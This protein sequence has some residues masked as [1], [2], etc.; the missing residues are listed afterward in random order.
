M[1]NLRKKKLKLDNE[2]SDPGPSGP[3]GTEGI[4]QS[5]VTKS[6]VFLS[7]ELHAFVHKHCN[8][9]YTGSRVRIWKPFTFAEEGR[10]VYVHWGCSNGLY[11]YWEDT[12]ING[13]V[14]LRPG[15]RFVVDNRG[16]RVGA[17]RVLCRTNTDDLANGKDSLS[18][19]CLKKHYN[20]VL[21]NDIFFWFPTKVRRQSYECCRFRKTCFCELKMRPKL[22]F[23]S[24]SNTRNPG[25]PY[26]G[27]YNRDKSES[28]CDF[29]AWQEEFDHNVDEQCKCGNHTKLIEYPKQTGK[30]FLVCYN[31]HREYPDKG[32][33]LFKQIKYDR[34]SL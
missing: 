17:L 26:Y 5:L 29:F 25:K 18:L 3:S 13:F 11:V 12:N 21:L 27:C 8:T 19:E 6:P 16:V 2:L 7:K 24:D 1:E 14:D 10:V 30:F 33:N 9:V 4:P 23:C 34:G 28:H 20:N 31:R 15:H 32:C 22:Y